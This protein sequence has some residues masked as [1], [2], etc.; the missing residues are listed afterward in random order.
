MRMTSAHKLYSTSKRRP[1]NVS[2][3]CDLVAEAKSSG[4]N[5]SGIA[6]AALLSAVG[7]ARLATWA[8]ENAKGIAAINKYIEEE[9]LPLS[10]LRLF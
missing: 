7:E 6:E 2:L 3:S 4:L 8:K 9:G 1:V 5:I 10:D